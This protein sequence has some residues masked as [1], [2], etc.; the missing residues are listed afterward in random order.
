MGRKP[1]IWHPGIAYHV[2]G[3]GNQ[4][5][6]LFK[7]DLDYEVFL[8]IMNR[9][10]E[11]TPYVL[12]AYCLMPNHYH[13]LLATED[14][15]LSN[16][17]ARINKG[18]ATY[19]NNRY[20]V[21]GHVFEKRFYS[22]PVMEGYGLAYVSRYIHNNPVVAHLSDRPAEYPWSSYQQY[23]TNLRKTSICPVNVA[24]ILKTYPGKVQEKRIHYQRFVEE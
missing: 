12:Y 19:F 6:K 7:D 14:H 10:N 24:K 16:L 17:M 23:L 4:K 2:T 20:G 11:K 1:R 21:T 8:R 15:P 22:Q 18:F 13:L 3:R 9:A 5:A